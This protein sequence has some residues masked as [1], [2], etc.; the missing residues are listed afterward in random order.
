MN[1]TSKPLLA[2]GTV[3]GIVIGVLCLLGL[4]ALAF[5]FMHRQ[6]RR[7][8][9][10]TQTFREKTD[11]AGLGRQLPQSSS[12]NRSST[13]LK[14][15]T[16][17]RPLSSLT[18]LSASLSSSCHFIK[19]RENERHTFSNRSARGA[20]GDVLAQRHGSPTTTRRL[21]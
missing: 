11:R 20:G 12:T 10:A 19:P 1:A 8:R 6:R 16:L 5:W 21:K 17:D 9:L 3:A 15:T 2:A 7:T 14:F 4:G 18:F 13:L